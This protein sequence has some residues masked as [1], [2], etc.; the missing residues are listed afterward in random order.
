MLL[1]LHSGRLRYAADTHWHWDH[2][3]GNAWVHAEGATLIA[4]PNTA[5]HLA[6]TIRVAEWG[7]TFSPVP[8]SAR[9]ALL[10]PKMKTLLLNGETIRIRSYVPSHTDGDLSVYFAKA[11]V[12]ATGDTWWNNIY[13]FIDYVAGGSIDGMIRAADANLAISDDRTAIVPGHGPVGTRTQL[14]QFRGMLS[15]VRDRVATLK[16]KGMTLQ[17]VIAANPTGRYDAEFG[18]GIINPALFTTLVYRGV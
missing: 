5:R 10:V 13:P 12:L 9:P 18:H 7:H 6:S 16:R 4:H 14:R 2:T 15:D 1:R 3:D 17:Q 8:K 11:N